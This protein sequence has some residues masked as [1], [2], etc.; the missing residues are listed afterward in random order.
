MAWVVAVGSQEDESWR[1][2]WPSTCGQPIEGADDTLIYVCSSGEVWIRRI[3][4]RDGVY[5]Y[6]R[7]I[8]CHIRYPIHPVHTKTVSTKFREGCLREM[9]GDMFIIVAQPG[10]YCAQKVVDISHEVDLDVLG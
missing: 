2:A 4:A 10:E 9:G 1:Y 5:W 7:P 6:A 8:G 3:R